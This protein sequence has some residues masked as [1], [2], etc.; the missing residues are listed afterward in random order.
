M[1]I[2][3]PCR[4][5]GVEPSDADPLNRAYETDEVFLVEARPQ[6]GTMR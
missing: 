3:E 1:R 6:R 4:G 2:V 5:G